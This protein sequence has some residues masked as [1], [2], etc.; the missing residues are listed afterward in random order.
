MNEGIIN[1]QWV[2]GQT[3]CRS[4]LRAQIHRGKNQSSSVNP[5]E[6][7]LTSAIMGFLSIGTDTKPTQV[8]H[9]A[10]CMVAVL[11]VLH[12]LYL[13]HSSYPPSTRPLNQVQNVSSI[14]TTRKPDF[15][16]KIWQTSKTSPAGLNEG[17]RQAIQSWTKINQK[18]RYEIITQ[19]SA[20][21]YVRDRFSH[22]KDIEEAF[23]DLQDPILRADLIRYLVLLGDGGI[24][25]D[26]DT[27]SLKPIED[28]IPGRYKGLA[29]V[30]VGVE[31]DRLDG[32]RW[33]DW[34]LDLQFCTWAIMAKPNHPLMDL[35]VER[36]MGRLRKL[37]L[38]QEKTLAGIKTSFNDVLDTTGPA[39]FTESVF[40]VLSRSTGTNFTHHNVTGLTKARLV[41]DILILPI[42]A[43]GSGQGHSNSGSPDEESALVQ[44][45][46][47]GSW[48][49]DHRME[50]SKPIEEKP[51]EGNES[52]KTEGDEFD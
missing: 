27:M 29:N 24:Y 23:L 38:K 48:K 26:I 20:E 45:L 21:S 50:E 52:E 51:D 43:F 35:T 2:D 15:P 34:T 10:Y 9:I 1:Q 30:V 18:W 31:Y 22:R 25:S 32:G 28:W 7:D 19:Y 36:V 46:F 47:K 39:I 4:F 3:F 44:H 13:F 8:A 6:S 33:V 17:D 42:N 41:D 14:P 12:F 37:A 5:T 40:E 16:R 11:I 49:D